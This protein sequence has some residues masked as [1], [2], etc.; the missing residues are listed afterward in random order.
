MSADAR[1]QKFNDKRHEV[2]RA[3]A[4][5]FARLGFHKSS[6]IDIG[7]ELGVTPAALYYYAKSKDQLLLDC[8]NCALA[9]IEDAFADSAQQGT[10]GWSKLRIFF[11]RYAEI[12]CSEFGRC[13]VI[14]FPEELA[15]ELQAQRKTRHRA[16]MNS[17]RKIVLEGIADGSIRACDHRVL[18]NLLF[19]A[20]NHLTRWW[21]PRGP[22]S[23]AEAGRAYLEILARGVTSKPEVALSSTAASSPKQPTKRPAAKRKISNGR[24]GRRRDRSTV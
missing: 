5:V 8:S 17:V 1:S 24:P 14:T 6:I 12:V 19:G 7:Q 22:L 18:T 4:R 20:M 2:L 11:D 15:P 3:A 16:L 23:P 13:L 21:S 9:E 10:D